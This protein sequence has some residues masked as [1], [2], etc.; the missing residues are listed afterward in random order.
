[1]T[2]KDRILELVH[3]GIIT[4]EEGIAL[5]EKLGDNAD[6]AKAKVETPVPPTE[7]IAPVAPV[8]P[9]PFVAPEDKIKEPFS[10]FEDDEDFAEDEEIH[11]NSEDEDE[12]DWQDQVKEAMEN[13]KATMD[14]AAETAK[15][16]LGSIFEQVKSAAEQVKTQLNDNVDWK[17]INIRVPKVAG[18]RFNHEFTFPESVATILEVENKN[19]DIKIK[20]WEGPGVKVVADGKIYGNLNGESP[21]EEFIKR[22]E[23]NV[24]SE[25]ISFKITDAKIAVDYTFYLPGLNYDYVALK[26]MNGD[27]ILYQLNAGD[28][29]LKSTNGDVVVD[30]LV[31]SMLEVS[32]VNGDVILRNGELIDTLINTVNGDIIVTASPQSIG[33]T[34]VNGDVKLT[35]NNENLKK[36][37]ATNVNG[38][39]KVALPANSGITGNL[40]STVGSIKTRLENIEETAKAKKNKDIYR[41]GENIVSV[42][43]KTTSGDVYVK[44]AE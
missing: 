7:P 25:K 17:D 12:A 19:G 2:E 1:M 23:I 11:F 32:G 30:V 34:L 33:V 22:S 40:S 43:L 15:P 41:T 44:D 36:V 10:A 37:N 28:V 3:K 14:K 38:D 21:V 29:Y 4:T 39:V 9:E 13:A 18:T 35:L 6:A 8:E 26:S 27:V 31:A 5:L 20:Q 42:V 16:F 24:D